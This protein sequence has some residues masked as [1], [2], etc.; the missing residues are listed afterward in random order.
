IKQNAELY[1]VNSD[2]FLESGHSWPSHV[3]PVGGA[4]I[5]F[6]K[7]L[8]YPWNTSISSAPAGLIIV[9]LGANVDGSAMPP[10][11]VK[12]FVGALS[13]LTKFRIYW[14]IGTNLSLKGVDLE[15]MPS[16]INVT[17]FIPQNDL[18]AHR[19]CKLLVTN[20]GSS[21]I[22]EALTYGV[23]I[24]GV[25]LYGVNYKNLWNVEQ[26]GAGL[27]LNKDKL[28]EKTL[29]GAMKKLLDTPIY[30]KKAENFAK[31]L[32]SRPGS[33]FERVLNAIELVA[34]HGSASL[35]RPS[36]RPQG[37][38]LFLEVSHLDFFLIVVTG[39]FFAIFISYIILR[40][41][42]RTMCW[43]KKVEKKEKQKKH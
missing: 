31:E 42:L 9:Q 25:P 17:T 37:L 3:I 23:P 12:A 15:N 35:I 13:K 26:R 10:A 39:L 30:K 8:F 11:L 22:L 40:T 36:K 41:F 20:G 21:S 38:L 19:R 27:M 32:K 2:P 34:R 33:A 24:L 5:D 4:H 16:H 6:P 29:L 18:L 1:L 7:P 28:D 43:R 14:R